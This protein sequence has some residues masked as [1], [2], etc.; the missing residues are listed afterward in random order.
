MPLCRQSLGRLAELSKLW[1]LPT[2]FKHLLNAFSTHYESG[3][4]LRTVQLSDNRKQLFKKNYDP[5]S[6]TC[7]FA[8]DLY[9]QLTN[10]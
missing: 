4:N 3:S 2:S 7:Q 10:N 1:L 6:Q 8:Q 5:K 9:Y